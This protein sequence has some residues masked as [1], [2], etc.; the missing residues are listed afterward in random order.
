MAK[1]PTDRVNITLRIPEHLRARLEDAASGGD[2]SLN[3]EIT[4]RL[5]KSFAENETLADLFGDDRIA[6]FL[7]AQASVL[8]SFREHLGNGPWRS[9]PQASEFVRGLVNTVMAGVMAP[10]LAPITG[11]NER[12]SPS[13]PSP[14]DVTAMARQLAQAMKP[15]T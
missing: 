11:K 13:S 1:T 10:N 4:D 14:D 12:L 3:A 8:R 9:D 6:S 7:L 5:E 15:Q 2:R